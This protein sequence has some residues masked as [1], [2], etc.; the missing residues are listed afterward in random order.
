M[1]RMLSLN[2]FQRF[3][4]RCLGRATLILQPGAHLFRTAQIHNMGSKSSDIVIGE[5]SLVRGELLRFAHG[6]R[7]RI[8]RQCYIGEG[9]RIWSGVDIC[10]GDHVLIAHNVSIFDNLTHPMDWKERRDQFAAIATTGHPS[11]ID[12]ADEPIAIGDDAWI[13]AHAIILKGVTIGPR[14]IVAAGS[15]VT[16]DVAA[17]TVVAGNPASFLRAVIAPVND[18][19]R[20]KQ[21]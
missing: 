9:T 8:G 15:V 10:I 16:R 12:L 19:S 18:E 14:A 11:N 17:D 2:F 20:E 13:G 4:L 6:G 3:V 7:I 21:C 5:G 1:K